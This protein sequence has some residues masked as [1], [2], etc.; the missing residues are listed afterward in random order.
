MLII[1]VRVHFYIYIFYSPTY[2][3]YF[4]LDYLFSFQ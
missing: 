3:M 4:K 2:K 1:N